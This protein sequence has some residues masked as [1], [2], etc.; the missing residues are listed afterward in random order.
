MDREEGVHVKY[1]LAWDHVFLRTIL[2]GQ[3]HFGVVSNMPAI[4]GGKC[5]QMFGVVTVIKQ[6]GVTHITGV[7][8]AQSSIITINGWLRSYRHR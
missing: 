1:T 6:G 8:F 5:S 2:D 4:Y 3:F 7:N